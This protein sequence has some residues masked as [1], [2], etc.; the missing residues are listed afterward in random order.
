[1]TDHFRERAAVVLVGHATRL[2]G[3]F[4]RE[5]EG[6]PVLERAL[7]AVGRAGFRPTIVATTPRT[8]PTVEVLLDRYDRGPLGGVRTFLEVAPGP[9]LLVGGDMPYL[10]ADALRRL[11]DLHRPGLSIV[12][13]WQGGELEVLH[14]MYDLR[15]ADVVRTWVAGRPLRD[16]VRA[17][18]QDGSVRTVPAEDIGTRSLTDLDTVADWERLA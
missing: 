9:F 7:R 11:A 14:A 16:L 8:H 5:I 2:P 17:G 10:D 3:K 4:D 6:V 18:I 15:P 12:P 13:R 1:M